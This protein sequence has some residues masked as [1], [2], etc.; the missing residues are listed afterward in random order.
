MDMNFTATDVMW[1]VLIAAS[2]MLLAKSVK[3]FRMKCAEKKEA[4]EP[5]APTE[6][7]S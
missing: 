5:E 3:R 7:A 4:A 1:V 6:A 2:V